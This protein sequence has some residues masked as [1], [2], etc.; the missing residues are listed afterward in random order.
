MIV[1]IPCDILLLQIHQVYTK[2]S[3]S[4]VRVVL[5]S[6]SPTYLHALIV[7]C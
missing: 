6:C 1:K 3:G 5:S 4:L 2:A 7:S